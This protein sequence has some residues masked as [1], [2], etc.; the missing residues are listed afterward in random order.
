M[1]TTEDMAL[2]FSA[3]F[4]FAYFSALSLAAERT[5]APLPPPAAFPA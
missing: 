2:R 1:N 5:D 3:A 4:D